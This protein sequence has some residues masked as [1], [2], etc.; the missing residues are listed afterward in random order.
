M[1]ARSYKVRKYLFFSHTLNNTVLGYSTHKN[2]FQQACMSKGS[3]IDSTFL[4]RHHCRY[5]L[6]SYRVTLCNPLAVLTVTWNVECWYQAGDFCS[7]DAICKRKCC[8]FG[9]CLPGIC[10]YEHRV[11]IKHTCYVFRS[12]SGT[13]YP[14]NQLW[15]NTIY[16]RVP[17]VVLYSCP[18]WGDGILW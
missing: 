5:D 12:K 15:H 3:R 18:A 17:P 9:W 7:P 14:L 1:K 8:R 10:N 13:K 16:H 6:I 11:A 4:R 2:F